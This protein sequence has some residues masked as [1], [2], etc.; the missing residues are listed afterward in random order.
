MLM[1]LPIAPMRVEDRDGATLQCLPPDCAIEIIQALRTTA[2]QGAQH[3]RRV[4]VEGRA[5]HR[6]HREDNMAIDDPLVEDLA[7]LADP[8][9]AV[10]FGTSSAQRRFAA[11]RHQVLPLATAQAAVFEVPYLLG[12][13]TP[14]HLRHQ[15]IVIRRLIPRMGV[16]KRLPV[17]RK[18]LLED[19]SVPRGC[20]NP[21]GAPSWGDT[22]ATVQRLYHGLPAS[23]TPHRPTYGHPCPS[24]LLLD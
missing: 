17:I 2:H 20:C 12:I 13:A 3:D 24:S 8:V 19:T 14:K 11:H 9:I 7:H 21:R 10:D 1:L 16:L 5:E 18:D 22:M 15:T 23:S 6:R 4:V